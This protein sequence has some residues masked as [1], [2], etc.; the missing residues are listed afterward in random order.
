MH[1]M[2]LAPI[3]YISIVSNHNHNENAP[4]KSTYTFPFYG[5]LDKIKLLFGYEF[6]WYILVVLSTDK[7]G[8]IWNLDN[9]SN[10]L[11]INNMPQI[12]QIWKFE[13]ISSFLL[14]LT[15]QYVVAKYQNIINLTKRPFGIA[16]CHSS[17]LANGH[18]IWK[19]PVKFK[20]AI[21]FRHTVN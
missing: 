19:P 7:F 18:N 15:L 13:L 20:L 11:N 14:V 6:K 3:S 16:I 12:Y 9:L 17:L 8:S 21:L 4:I 5:S 2:C 1:F 10:H